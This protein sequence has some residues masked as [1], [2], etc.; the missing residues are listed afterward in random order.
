[1]KPKK[2]R[3]ANKCLIVCTDTEQKVKGVVINKTDQ[4]LVVQL[5]TGFHMELQKSPHNRKL[6]VCRLGMCEFISDGW[7][8]T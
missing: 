1:M 6:Y 2:V 7:M 8:Q 3:L 5:P 4:Q